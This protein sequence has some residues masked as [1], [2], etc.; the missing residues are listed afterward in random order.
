MNPILAI[1]MGGPLILLFGIIAAV[2]LG[3][4]AGYV[5]GTQMGRT[6]P[7]TPLATSVHVV[8]EALASATN[9]VEKAS[10][11]LGST[12]RGELAASAKAIARRL[13]EL[14]TG[15]GSVERK[16]KTSREGSA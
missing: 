9:R 2:A 14:S 11:K 4:A 6:R 16:S 15:L 8:R 13:S 5:M 1:D 7:A 10:T 12:E 3:C